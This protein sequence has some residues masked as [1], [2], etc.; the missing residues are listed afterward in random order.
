MIAG[1]LACP[2][3]FSTT[4][5][6]GLWGQLAFSFMLC[7]HATFI[8]SPDVLCLPPVRFVMCAPLRAVPCCYCCCCSCWDL[9]IHTYVIWRYTRDPGAS[10]LAEEDC[11]NDCTVCKPVT[12]LQRVRTCLRECLRKQEE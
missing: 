4:N 1:W 8:A 9:C 6:L 10:H 5:Q 2:G 12:V 3:V 7:L 11:G